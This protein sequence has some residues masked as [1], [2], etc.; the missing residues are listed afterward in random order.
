MQMT[1]D[2]ASEPLLLNIT[3]VAKLLGLSRTKVYALIA[4]EGLP[5]IPFGRVLRVSPE[6]LK[7]WLQ[8]RERRS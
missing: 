4:T 5:V 1:Q 6:S 7:E 3:Q 2:I 8:Q